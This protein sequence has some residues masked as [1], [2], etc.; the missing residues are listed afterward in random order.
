MQ[1]LFAAAQLQKNLG[2]N[3]PV[4]DGI[5]RNSL[6]SLL[7]STAISEGPDSYI[8]GVA[9]W[10]IG[11][12]FYA[13]WYTDYARRM[14]YGFIGSDSRGR[15]YNQAGNFFARNAVLQWQGIVSANAA[16]VKNI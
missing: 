9:G 14:E 7:N 6:T 1:D 8:V 5:L 16:K 12:T 15:V 13:G 11:D 2:G 3:M 4:D 10:E